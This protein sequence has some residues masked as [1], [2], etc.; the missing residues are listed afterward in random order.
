M[1]PS[2]TFRTTGAWG[3]GKGS[4]LTSAEVD[5]NFYE[6]VQA[7]AGI[8][9]LEPVEI[10]NITFDPEANTLTVVMEDATEFGPFPLPQAAFRWTGDWQDGYSYLKYD[11]FTAND[12]LY[13]VLQAHDTDT[14]SEFN[15]DDG[16]MA[17]PFYQL[18]LPFPNLYDIG[19]FFPGQ[20]GY[21]IVEG[22]AMFTLRANKNFFLREDLPGSEAGIEVENTSELVF[23]VYKNDTEIGSFTIPAP[24]SSESEPEGFFTFLA[25]VQFLPGDRLRVLRPATLDATARDFSMNIAGTR[26]T[27]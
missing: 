26:G 18:I 2:I 25:D 9:A 21:G 1:P 24:S 3:A 6:L 5:E 17:G 27:L 10:A 8:A 7:L 15:P 19:F 12:G 11:F 20:P 14:D 23:P 4:N 13:L 22:E 16:N